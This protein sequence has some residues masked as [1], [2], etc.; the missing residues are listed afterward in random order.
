[1]TRVPGDGVRRQLTEET[2]V[3]RVRDRL[4]GLDHYART[5]AVQDANNTAQMIRVRVGDECDGQIPSPVARQERHHDPASGVAAVAPGAGIDQHPV[6]RRGAKERTV[7][8][9]HVEKM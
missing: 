2:I 3:L 1:M 7:S 9:P 4:A 6:A 8:L 5:K